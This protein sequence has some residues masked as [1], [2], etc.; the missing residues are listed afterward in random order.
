MTEYEI[1][2]GADFARI[3]GND[4]VKIVANNIGRHGDHDPNIQPLIATAIVIALNKIN[5]LLPAVK[6][7]VVEMISHD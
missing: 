7:I 2:T 5:T 4:I 6:P 3:M 1:Q